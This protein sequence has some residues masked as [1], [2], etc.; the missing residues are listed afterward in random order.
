MAS[1]AGQYHIG[2]A[3]IPRYLAGAASTTQALDS[4]GDKIGCVFVA[5]DGS[6]AIDTIEVYCT[7]LTGTSPTYRVVLQGYNATGGIANGTDSGG[8]SPT[9]V[10]FTAVAGTLHSLTLTNAFTPTEGVIYVAVL[11][12]ASGTIDVSNFATF[13]RNYTPISNVG[14]PYVISDTAGSWAKVTSLQPAITPI[15]ASGLIVPGTEIITAADAGA[16]GSGSTPDEWGNMW[17]PDDS[18]TCIGVQL[19]GRWSTAAANYDLT[20]YDTNGTSVLAS[21]SI[22]GEAISGAGNNM[23]VEVFWE[24]VSITGG[25][26]YRISIKP[27]T[28]STIRMFGLTFASSAHRA[29]M[30]GPLQWTQQTDAGGWSQTAAKVATIGPILS[31]IAAG[32]GASG[33]GGRS[34]P[35]GVL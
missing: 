27:T 16:R 17:T 3:R 26:N 11:E 32:G 19:M 29:S 22:D 13:N 35:R 30:C 21:A 7:A 6:Q 24:A 18:C 14:L 25:S 9:S 28:V 15:Y 2:A 33:G 5:P 20:L 34:Y 23:T 8:G 12:Y 4:S 10:D 31:D 1:A